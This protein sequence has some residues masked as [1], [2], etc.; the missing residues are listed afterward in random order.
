MTTSYLPYAPQQQMLLP[1]AL[2]EW[3]P[4]GHLVYYISDSIDSLDLS[5]F[6]ARYAG[7][8]SRNQPFHPSMMV[9]VLVYGYATGV[10]S[11]RK[12]ASK[13]HEDVAFRVLAAGNFP[14]HRTL[15]D[16]RAL[17][18]KEL[19]DLFLQVVKLAQEC[20]LVRLGTIAVD[21]T[22][23]KANASRHKAMSY[24][25]MQKVELELK[26]QIAALLARAKAADDAEKNAPELDIPAEIARREDRP[27]GRASAPN[28][29]R[30]WS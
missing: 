22:K 15:S 2:Q 20:G 25:R 8:G 29:H 4:E 28:R 7:G 10:F 12:L 27:I 5:A 21:G 26:Q 11:S 30:A 17:H 16:F 24:E 13:L 1:H 3:L 23:I 14:A 9:K 18:L 19:S 6:H